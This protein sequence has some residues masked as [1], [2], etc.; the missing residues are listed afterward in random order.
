M[1]TTRT[2]Y[3]SQLSPWERRELE[4][5]LAYGR[6]QVNPYLGAWTAPWL[7]CDI[8]EPVWTIRTATTRRT[9]GVWKGVSRISWEILLADGTRLTDACNLEMRTV[10]QRAGFLVRHFAVSG[11]TACLSH[12]AWISDFLTIVRWLY[13]NADVYRPRSHLFTRVTHSAI[14]QFIE[15]YTS[16]GAKV[17]VLQYPE[18]FVREVYER[19][20]NVR[21]S[22][23]VLQ[24]MFSIPVRD[25]DQIVEWLAANDFYEAR[26]LRA[27]RV[28]FL[29]RERVA[30]FI[31]ADCKDVKSRRL[32]AF[33]RQ[34]EPDLL[35]LNSELLLP[36]N[37]FHS[38]YP[39]HRVPRIKDVVAA[40]TTLGSCRQALGTWETLFRV[41]IHLPDAIASPDNVKF[42][43]LRRQIVRDAQPNELT[44]WVPLNTSLAYSTESLRW[45]S[46]YGDELVTLYVAAVETFQKNGWF[47]DRG[48]SSSE[49]KRRRKRRDQWIRENL[50]D[51]LKPLGIDRWGSLLRQGQ[52]ER[53]YEQMRLSP[54]LNDALQ[55][56]VG[57]ASLLIATMKP[58]RESELL[59]LKRDCV[60]F[61]DNDGYWL[62]HVVRKSN[63]G[64]LL[65]HTQRPIP[66]IVA[67]A[68]SQ[69]A[70]L[71]EHL[72]RLVE[73][74]DRQALEA[75]FYLPHFANNASLAPRLIDRGALRTCIDAFC[76][77][78]ALPP[79]ELGRRWYVRIHE[80]RKSFLITFFW[81]FKYSSID[82]ARWIAGHQSH[83]HIYHYIRANFPGMELPQLEAEYAAMQLWEFA[84]TGSV[85]ETT[86]VQGLY[87][88]VCKHFRVSELSLVS[89][90][91]LNDWLELAFRRGLYKVWP[92]SFKD[93]DG[94]RHT[95]IAFR[96]VARATSK[97]N[98]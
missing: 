57:A 89:E 88:A 42:G 25:R 54:G 26:T 14:Q 18:T 82:A 84:A 24:N 9:N 90:G 86:N 81:C 95:D 85:G 68:V 91:D 64:D 55:V 20:L 93:A 1:A 87:K 19:A 13:L 8:T 27:G 37:G 30:N 16:G 61:V 97:E 38:E 76:D 70:R 78:V 33:L 47:V 62:E 98:R 2:E 51:S 12:I 28:R 50:P 35:K 49:D 67:K 45:I 5:Q 58:L 66:A 31:G 7:L 17:G 92:F 44:P 40:K 83:L 10:C 11:I 96:I 63:I 4:M 53:P 34:F 72:C 15:S 3:K 43:I 36:V 46:L 6:A 59:M 29:S 22:A 74:P 71:S 75:L 80:L 79:D 23:D 41:R 65:S 39:S 94:E 73:E 56:L 69:F 60:T 52:A 77:Y 48:K 21:P 32:S